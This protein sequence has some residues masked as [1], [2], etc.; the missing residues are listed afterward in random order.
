[1]CL[2]DRIK[3]LHSRVISFDQELISFKSQRQACHD[4]FNLLLWCANLPFYHYKTHAYEV[5]AMCRLPTVGVYIIEYN[6]PRTSN[7]Q[8]T[9]PDK[10]Q[11]Y[12]KWPMPNH[13]QANYQCKHWPSIQLICST[14][15]NADARF[16]NSASSYCHLIK[17]Q[18]FSMKTH[19]YYIVFL[20]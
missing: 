3:E 20:L 17:D 12:V 1:M 15:W 5:N 4:V 7:L 18:L 16:E 11:G 13:G 9:Q 2:E 10:F 8:H 19:P 14:H 6:V